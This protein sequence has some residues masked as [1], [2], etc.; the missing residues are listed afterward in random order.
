MAESDDALVAEV[1]E[2]TNELAKLL[3]DFSSRLRMMR[4]RNRQLQD[5]IISIE[6]DLEGLRKWLAET[7]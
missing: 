7:T 5:E 3:D 6:D 2:K 1:R 4:E